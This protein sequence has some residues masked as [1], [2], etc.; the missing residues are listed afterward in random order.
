MVINESSSHNRED[1]DHCMTY[2]ESTIRE[3]H[4]GALLSILCA[5][6]LATDIV[7]PITCNN[8]RYKCDNKIVVP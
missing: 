5:L 1:D 6:I 8:Y 3:A 7:E 4:H 2:V